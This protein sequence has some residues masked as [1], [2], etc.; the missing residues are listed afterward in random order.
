MQCTHHQVS[1]SRD[2]SPCPRTWKVQRSGMNTGIKQVCQLTMSLFTH[3]RYRPSTAYDFAANM[4]GHSCA[5]N[6]SRGHGAY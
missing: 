5:F 1:N 2:T 6:N 3:R 4:H